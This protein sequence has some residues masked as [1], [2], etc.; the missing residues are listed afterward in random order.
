MTETLELHEAGGRIPTREVDGDK[1]K[2]RI[3]GWEPGAE[4]TNG[5]S[6]DYPVEVLKRDVPTSFPEGTRMKANHDGMCEAGGDIRR[7]IARTIDTPWAEADGMYTNIRVSDQ[8]AGYVK[9]YGDI[10][11]LSISAAGE[12]LQQENEDGDMM[13]AINE[14]TGKPILKRLLSAEESPYNSID[15]VEAP[16]A[17]GRIVMALEAAQQ[18]LLELNIREQASFAA[19]IQERKKTSEAVPPR[20]NKE[21]YSM[22]EKEKAALVASVTEGVIA[23]L[24]AAIAEAS[25]PAENPE[26]RYEDVAEAAIEAGLTKG[27]RA[28][29][30]EAV[31]GGK[32]I[33]EAVSDA[34]AREKEIE[35]AISARSTTVSEQRVLGGSQSGTLEEDF[36][37]VIVPAGRGAVA[38]SYSTDEIDNMWGLGAKKDVVL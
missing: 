38:E 22:D 21:E 9:E 19:G 24:P 10:I 34:K 23:S 28:G 29:V 27:S 4:F 11:G 15:F 26:I 3:M 12:L 25:K 37:G 5:S 16:G 35:E 17:D 30:Y 33:A 8:W 18:K 14:E 32:T 1:Y 13:N 7:V 6:A 31:R 20:S 36:A 2:V